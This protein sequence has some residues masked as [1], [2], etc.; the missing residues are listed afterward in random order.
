MSPGFIDAHNHLQDDS[1]KPHLGGVLADLKSAGIARAVVNGTAENDWDAVSEL[2]RAHPWIVPSYGLHPWF[3]K[4]RTPQWRDRLEQTLRRSPGCA[5]G[6]IG[7]DR[8]IPDF[9]IADQQT[10]YAGQLRLAAALELPVTVHC[11]QAWGLLWDSMRDEPPPP[12]GFLLH[13]YGGPVEM[14][15]LFARRGGYFS[16]SGSF[17]DARKA[18]RR[19]AFRQ[20]PPERLLV[21]TDAPAMPLPAELRRW[22]LPDSPEGKPV[23]HPANLGVVYEGLARLRGWSVE[24]LA[25]QVAEN[26][27]RLFGRK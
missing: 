13:A 18:G 22:T 14:I 19:E 4:T 1:L 17:L 20:V 25:D 12:R 6:E 24:T 16:F 5:I 7:L 26:F 3:L 2:A 21:E 15:E 11:L 9:D 23:N 10:V 8:W 27:E